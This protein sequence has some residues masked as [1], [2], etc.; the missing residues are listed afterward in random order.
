MFPPIKDTWLFRIMLD[1]NKFPSI[2][3]EWLTKG[4][5]YGSLR[6]YGSRNSQSRKGGIFYLDIKIASA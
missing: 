6:R 3:S 2:D 1:L 5:G 4:P